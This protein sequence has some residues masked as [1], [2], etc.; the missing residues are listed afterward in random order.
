MLENLKKLKGVAL[1]KEIAKRLKVYTAAEA[2]LDS[3]LDTIGNLATASSE[4]MYDDLEETLAAHQT[5]LAAMAAGSRTTID[6]SGD[7]SGPRGNKIADHVVELS[8]F[9]AP[10]RDSLVKNHSLLKKA[11]QY[12]DELDFMIATLGESTDKDDKALL[13]TLIQHR[14][15]MREKKN[16]AQDV[17]ESL[18]ERHVPNELNRA[19]SALEDHVA[20]LLGDGAEHMVGQWFLSND[21]ESIDFSYYLHSTIQD[22]HQHNLEVYLVLTGRIQET[23]KGHIM[24]VFLTSMNSFK[25]PGQFEPGERINFTSQQTLI[26]SLKREANRLMAKQG[27]VAALSTNKLNVT[28]RQLRDAGITRLKHVIDLR[29]QGDA[30]Y[31]LLSNVDDR[32]IERDTVPDLIVLLKNTLHKQ[33]ANAVFMRNLTST[34]SN[35]KMMKIISVNEV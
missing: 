22:H 30:V 24:R 1:R 18:A 3:F 31:L 12:Q 15:L 28:T 32:D 13:K 27:L 19:A 2:K 4:E 21:A 33:K 29:V 9:T 23:A 20:V 26:N 17:L 10:P 25:L 7:T 6:V 8:K 5:E 35:K 14:K 34:R 16:K 11:R